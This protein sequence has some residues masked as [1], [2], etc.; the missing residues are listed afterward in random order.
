LIGENTKNVVE[1]LLQSMEENKSSYE[2]YNE[3]W[4]DLIK[5]IQEVFKVAGRKKAKKD[6][7][8]ER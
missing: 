8:E 4:E 6:K 2:S 1:N 5:R 7:E 3:W